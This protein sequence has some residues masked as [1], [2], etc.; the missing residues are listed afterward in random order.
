MSPDKGVTLLLQAF[1]QLLK[2]CND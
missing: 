2:E 1:E